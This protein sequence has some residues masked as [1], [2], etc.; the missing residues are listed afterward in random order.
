[1]LY[2]ISVVIRMLYNCSI[3]FI[4]NSGKQWPINSFIYFFKDLII[5][6]DRGEEGERQGNMVVREERRLVASHR[7]L[8]PTH[9]P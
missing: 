5:C 7:G 3:Y 6:R 4:I 8:Q 9:V 2:I 1:M